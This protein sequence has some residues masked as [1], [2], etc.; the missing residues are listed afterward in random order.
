MDRRAVR[1]QAP[2]GRR[3]HPG[4]PGRVRLRRDGGALRVQ[5]RGPPRH[6]R[7]GRVRPGHR[8]PGA[9]LGPH[10][11]LPAG[12]RAPVPGQ[13]PDHAGVR[14]PARAEPAQGVRRP[15]LPGRGRDRRHRRRPGRL[16]RRR[17]RGDH[18]ERPGPGPQV[19][20]DRPG[21]Q[22]RAAARHRRRPAGRAVHRAPDEDRAGRPAARHVR[23][24]RRGAAPDPGAPDA[25]RLL[26]RRHRGG[27]AGGQVPHAGDRALG[28]LP[29]QRRRA[30]APARP[31]LVRA[32]RARLRHPAQPRGRRR[33]RDVLALRAR[34]RDPGPSLGAARPAGAG[35]P[36]RRPR[37]GGRHGERLLRG[38]QPRAHGAPPS[39]Q[40]RRHR[41]RHPAGRGQRRDRGCAAA[42]RELGLHLRRRGRGRQADPGP[43]HE[44][45]PRPPAPP[46]SAARQPGRG[47]AP[48]H[49][50]ARPRGE[51]RAS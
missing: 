24:P 51:P 10:R 48:L 20:D 49:A 2:G 4:L 50:G 18:D 6:L 28:R 16:L 39:R 35:A 3:Q 36:H 9:G 14:H 8:E 41:L 25:E 42:A 40:D 31:R 11:R 21:H 29:G 19:R 38:G 37:E 43:R 30:L 26:R 17:P 47:A 33:H 12:R 45:G 7:E 44:G 13:L 1:R 34:P 15:H 22:P 32:D 46:L 27:P 5:L 23:P